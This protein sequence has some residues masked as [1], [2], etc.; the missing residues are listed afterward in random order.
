[1][2]LVLA[3]L[4]WKLVW[5][6]NMQRKEKIGAIVAMSMGVFAGITGIIKLSMTPRMKEG[7]VCKF[8]VSSPMP[9][10]PYPCHHDFHTTVL[11]TGLLTPKQTTAFPSSSGAP[12]SPR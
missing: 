6:L 9:P 12:P 8:F 5:P 10:A 4:P 7:D 3:L 11:L 2:D 1:M